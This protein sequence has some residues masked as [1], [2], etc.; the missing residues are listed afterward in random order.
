MYTNSITRF[1]IDSVCCLVVLLGVIFGCNSIS[2]V[3]QK[4]NSNFDQELTAKP[5]QLPASQPAA[6]K[7]AWVI[8]DRSEPAGYALRLRAESRS[9]YFTALV[10]LYSSFTIKKVEVEK[11]IGERGGEIRRGKFLNQFHD[12]RSGEGLHIGEDIDAVTGA[13]ISSKAF[14]EAV[15]KSVR[16]LASYR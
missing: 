15:R 8:G 5:L 12:K 2:S 11:Y 3:D 1:A 16:W 13:T 6:V 14:T 10:M 4:V 7:E 9:G